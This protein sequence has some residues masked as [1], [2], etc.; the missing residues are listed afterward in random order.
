VSAAVTFGEFKG[1]IEFCLA[2]QTSLTITSAVVDTNAEPPRLDRY[3][4][5]LAAALLGI[6]PANV[7]SEGLLTL[8][9]LNAAAPDPESDVAFLPSVRAV[10]AVKACQAWVLAEVEDEDDEM[11]EDVESAMLPIFGHLAPILQGVPGAHWEFVFDVL[12]GVLERAKSVKKEENDDNQEEGGKTEDLVALARA[13]RLVSVLEDLVQTNKSL[14]ADWEPR[15]TNILVMIRDLAVLGEGESPF[16]GELLNRVGLWGIS[17][18][19]LS[20]QLAESCPESNQVPSAPR[21]ACRELVLSVVRNLPPSL[22]DKD[23]LGKVS[24][25]INVLIRMMLTAACFSVVYRWFI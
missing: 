24:A 19:L 14:R 15:R 21:S 1:L 5:E 10:N 3:R 17:S 11:S 2:P 6:K 12:E 9:K 8:R 16:L 4:N 13:L 7:N 20:D 18:S 23:T 25:A 22:M